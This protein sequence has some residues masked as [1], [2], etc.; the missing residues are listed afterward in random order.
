MLI[1]LWVSV[2][3][4]RWKGFILFFIIFLA[5]LRRSRSR[6]AKEDGR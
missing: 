5:T 3:P 2:D 6:A 1:S 4:L